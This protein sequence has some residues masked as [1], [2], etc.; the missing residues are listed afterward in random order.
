MLMEARRVKG[1]VV[2][3]NATSWQHHIRQLCPQGRYASLVTGTVTTYLLVY[4]AF[5]L[6]PNLLYVAP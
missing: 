2:K 4:L 6:C 5:L 1:S 3:M